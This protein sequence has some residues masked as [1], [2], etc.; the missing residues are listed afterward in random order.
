MSYNPHLPQ[1]RAQLAES[2]QHSLRNLGF[3]PQPSRAG[4]EEVW[5]LKVHNDKF[6][7]LV[8]TS[9]ETNNGHSSCRAVGEDAIRVCA[10][11]LLR[12]GSVRMGVVKEKRVNRTGTIEDIVSR[13]NG[14]ITEVRNNISS[15]ETCYRC[16]APTFISKKGN[17]VCAEI[18]FANKD[19]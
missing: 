16:G 14:R 7:I 19:R 3:T 5:G 6:K 17:R 9:I 10:I 2:I 18:C 11:Y 15:V 13:I 1:D 12:D 4:S 8:Y